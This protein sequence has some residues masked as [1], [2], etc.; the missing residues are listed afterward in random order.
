MILKLR[1]FVTGMERVPIFKILRYEVEDNNGITMCQF[2]RDEYAGLNRLVLKSRGMHNVL[3]DTDK[4]MFL[5]IYARYHDA[6][7][8]NFPKEVEG[9]F[10]TKVGCYAYDNFH[11]LSTALKKPMHEYTK[12]KGVVTKSTYWKLESGGVTYEAYEVG[13]G[14]RG[15]FCCIKSNGET[16]AVIS[17]DLV[18][19]NKET[20]FDIYAETNALAPVCIAFAIL[21]D[22]YR[23]TGDMCRGKR[24]S[25][26]LTIHKEQKAQYDA[27]FID[28]IKKK[29]GNGL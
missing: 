7:I 8:E 18:E 24:V 27:G 23:F 22:V 25:T 28:Y 1:R 19:I 26:V 3:L 21:W 20:Y 12:T 2:V 9:G 16:V 6:Q 13:L 15:A 11:K 4:E 14:K 29:D 17:K 10:Q 5:E